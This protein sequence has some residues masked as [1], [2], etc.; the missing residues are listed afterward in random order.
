MI[1]ANLIQEKKMSRKVG[2]TRKRLPPRVERAQVHLPP[3]PGNLEIPVTN[4]F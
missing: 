3:P 2:N 4:G 1:K